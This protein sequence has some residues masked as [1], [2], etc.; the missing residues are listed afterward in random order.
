MRGRSWRKS[1]NDTNYDA[2]AGT[3]FRISVFKEENGNFHRL[4]LDEGKNPAKLATFS[5]LKNVIVGPIK[6]DTE[7][8]LKLVISKHA[9]KIFY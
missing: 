9:C 6:R 5:M 2:V 3:I 4:S 7:R 8:L 1:T